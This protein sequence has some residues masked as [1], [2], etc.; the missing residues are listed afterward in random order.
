MPP[1]RD[2]PNAIPTLWPF[3]LL[4]AA[5][6]VCIDLGRLHRFENSDSLIPILVSLYRWTPFFW[7]QNRY[8]ML[9]PL[10][11]TPFPH[12]LVNLLIQDGLTVFACLT[13]MFLLPRYLLRDASYPVVG[14]VSIVAF[15]LLAPPWQAFL[16]LVNTCYGTALA[17]GLGGLLLVDSSSWWRRFLALLFVLLAHWVYCA[18]LLLLAPL[19]IFR[20]LVFRHTGGTTAALFLLAL[21]GFGGILLTRL[22]PSAHTIFQLLPVAE[23][24]AGWTQLVRNLWLALA[25]HRWPLGLTVATVFCTLCLWSRHVRRHSGGAWRTCAV[26]LAA[27]VPNWLFMGIQRHVQLN[28]FDVRYLL[29]SVFLVQAGLAAT[30]GPLVLCLEGRQ[31]KVISAVAQ[32]AV[33][34]AILCST[35]CPSLAVVRD[36]LDRT[37]GDRTEDVVAA[38]C[39]HIAGSYW[40][41]WATV[42]HTN[43]LRY[44]QGDSA[45]LWGI[46]ER[47]GPTHPMWKPAASSDLCVAVPVGDGRA[48]DYLLLRYGFPNLAVM[49]KRP[50]I[51]VLRP[52]Q[53]LATAQGGQSAGYVPT[54]N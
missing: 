35:G 54:L 51:W 4:C 21:G 45:I 31:R 20:Y 34:G 53:P 5:A 6:A 25:P 2:Q 14:A 18:V 11:A 41:V 13:A 28:D 16:L 36:D 24:P 29:P 26:L 23:W 12:P 9:V 39:T 15:L 47:C 27:A 50:S 49:E 22:A 8:G 44:E 32:V 38:G 1:R 33:L 40:N 52:K 3:L 43:W 17:L 46:A 19:V 30:V 42:F 48:G 37:L 10:L 7:E